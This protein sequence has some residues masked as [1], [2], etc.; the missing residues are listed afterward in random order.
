MVD[1]SNPGIAN[2]LGLLCLTSRR[3][4]S[5]A[6]LTQKLPSTHVDYIFLN[7]LASPYGIPISNY[8]TLAGSLS[9]N[10]LFL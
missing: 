3:V 10:S 5:R 9:A 7:S 6:I 2:N 8:L 1:Y 4:L